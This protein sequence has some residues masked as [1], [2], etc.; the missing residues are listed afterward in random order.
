MGNR[1]LTERDRQQKIF[2]EI[3]Q[4]YRSYIF[5]VITSVLGSAGTREDAEELVQDTLYALWN[6]SYVLQSKNLK[7]YLCV[8]A[9]NQAKNWL[10]GHHLLPIEPDV[11]EIPDPAGS[12]EDITV[13]RELSQQLHRAMRRLSPRD[14]EIFLLHYFYLQTAGEIAGRLGVPRNTVLSRLARG[15]K[16]LQ[17]TLNK[18]GFF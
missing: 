14:R 9:R 1:Q 2:Q 12:L 16:R 6:H 8:T 11:V 5:L 10:R 17:K 13:Q 18:E 4:K 15:R 3:A 7:S